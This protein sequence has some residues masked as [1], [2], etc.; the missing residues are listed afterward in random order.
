MV[1]A[2]PQPEAQAQGAQPGA[3][4][5]K[6]EAPTR[7]PEVAQPGTRVQMPQTRREQFL[8]AKSLKEEGNLYYR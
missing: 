5:S 6:V 3:E 7:Y 2:N 8:Y 1:E 4:E